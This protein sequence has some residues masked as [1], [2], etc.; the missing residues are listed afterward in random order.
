VPARIEM[1]RAFRMN[2]YA[3]GSIKNEYK[4]INLSSLV[5]QCWYRELE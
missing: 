3:N 5:D 4:L 1:K 2:S